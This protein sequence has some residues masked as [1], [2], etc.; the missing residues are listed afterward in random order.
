MKA[1]RLKSYGD[2]DQLVINETIPIV[3]T[4]R[5]DHIGAAQSAVAS[6]VQGKVVLTY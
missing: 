4:F 1:A 2:V 5:L 3:K 6:G